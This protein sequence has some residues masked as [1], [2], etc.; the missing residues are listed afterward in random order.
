LDDIELILSLEK[1]K[2]LSIDIS[3]KVEIAKVTEA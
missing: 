1:S 2:E 3:N